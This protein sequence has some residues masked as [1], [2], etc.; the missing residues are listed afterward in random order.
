M[1]NI[2]FQ[3]N[4]WITANLLAAISAVTWLVQPVYRLAMSR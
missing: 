1:Y 4:N 3:W 2:D